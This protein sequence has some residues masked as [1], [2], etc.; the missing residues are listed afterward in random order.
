M[1]FIYVET[2]D[3]NARYFDVIRAGC[4]RIPLNCRHHTTLDAP[5]TNTYTLG[6]PVCTRTS[7]YS[8][9]PSPQNPYALAGAWIQH[10]LSV[11]AYLARVCALSM[12]ALGNTLYRRHA[13]YELSDYSAHACVLILRDHIVHSSVSFVWDPSPGVRTDVLTGRAGRV[14]LMELSCLKR[15]ELA[16]D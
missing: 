10:A 1:E 11:L 3:A 7:S 15:I 14:E 12:G 13:I 4:I 6:W 8:R 16:D 2:G 5:K 9:K